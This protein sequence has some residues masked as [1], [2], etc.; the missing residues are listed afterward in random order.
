MK[1]VSTRH[2]VEC[3]LTLSG[4]QAA[5]GRVATQTTPVFYCW[6]LKCAVGSVL[7]S[8]RRQGG[9]LQGPNTWKF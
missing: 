2:H 6:F 3:N 4:S 9:T 8:R 1:S 5:D 7:V